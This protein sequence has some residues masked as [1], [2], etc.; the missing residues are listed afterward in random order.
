METR[1]NL[2][3]L[4][5]PELEAWVQAA[6]SRPFRARQLQHWLYKRGIADFEAMTDLVMTYLSAP[7]MKRPTVESWYSNKYAGNIKL[8]PEQWAKVS[9]GVGQYQKYLS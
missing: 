2:L 5:P 3:G 6:G 4:P 1:V 8:T 7:G 9:E